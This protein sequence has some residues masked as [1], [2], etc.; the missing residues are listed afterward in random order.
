MLELK[1]NLF[2]IWIGSLLLLLPFD[3]F[4]QRS[5]K[6]QKAKKKEAAAP[7]KAP[8]QVVPLTAPGSARDSIPA[9]DSLVLPK[10]SAKVDTV[11]GDLSTT[12]VYTAEDS[13][14]MEAQ[15]KEVHLYGNASVTYGEINLKADYIRLNWVLNE[16]YAIGREDT[17]TKKMVGEPI[18]Q[19]GQSTYNTK[20]IRYNFKTKKG[21]IKGIITQEGDGNIRGQ[22][23]KKDS[24]N[25]FYLAKAMYTTCNMEHPHYYINAPKIKL[26][27]KKQ[28]ISGLFNLV[29][30][31]VPLPLGLPFGFFPLPKNK[32]SGTSGILFPTYGED[33]MR[34]FYLRDGGYYFAINEY[35]NAA[36][37]G[38]FYTSGSWGV[39]LESSYMSRYK[40]SGNV[41]LRFNR[42]RS[43]DEVNKILKND[44]RNDF[45]LSWSHTPKPRGSST[46]SANVNIGSD[47]YNSLNA[48]DIN[49]YISNTASSS[50]QYNKTFGSF[51]RAG[52]SL[53]V[54]QNFGSIDAQT[55]I[56]KNG[57]TNVSSD[58][59]FGINQFSPFTIGGQARGRW[60]E[61]FRLGMDFSG[62]YGVTNTLAAID[63]SYAT[64]R[65][66][67][68]NPIDT[69]RLKQK[70]L[71]I[72]GPN[73]PTIFD[74]G[75]FQGRYSI[76]ISLP[77]MKL[78]K[79]I[80]VTPSVSFQGELFNRAY[81]YTYQGNNRI[82]ID[83][84]EAIYT[85][86]AY[87]FG[88]GMN[89]RFYGLFQVRKGRLETIR[90][91]VIPN[92]S[93][94]YTPDFSRNRNFYQEVQINDKGEKRTFSKYKNLATGGNGRASGMVNFGLGNQLEMK[95]RSKNDTAEN[96]FE[97][98]SLL[99][100]LS[101]NG[102]YNL[103]ADSLN[104][105]N[106]S[107]SA[108]TRLGK[109]LNMNFN[110]NFDPYIYEAYPGSTSGVRV[111]KFAITHGQGLA[112]L[113][114]MNFSLNTSFNPAARK[115]NTE[116]NKQKTGASEEQLEFI[117][118]NPDLYVDFNIPWNVNVSYNFGWNR[119]GLAPSNTVQALNF[120]GDLSLTPKWKI[121]VS[122]G[123]DFAAL[124]PTITQVT[125]YRDLHC[126]EMSLSWTPYAGSSVRASNYNF[127]LKVKSS[128]LQDLKLTRRRSFYD[129]GGMY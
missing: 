111:N 1:K 38:Q 22:R 116:Q 57:T 87:N 61:S 33:A 3:T 27:E 30:S 47:S 43:G 102:N 98:V 127:T 39:G 104:L 15:K 31:D 42:N 8:A 6:S 44:I 72:N 45:K 77:N 19:E 79:H 62:N 34:G 10:D 121:T 24:L 64:L 70:V 9:G 40:Y 18:F 60:Y 52:A 67:I 114:N 2:I 106:I 55:Q 88:A 58:F 128:I 118:Q 125:I 110:M 120:N 36:I 4:S 84:T 92:V 74:N 49:T 76:P 51:A 78:L 124:S 54:N 12:V 119:T 17:A 86:Y 103:L 82:R 53:R 112:R 20:E 63:T 126:W 66:I 48:A 21:I 91:T 113:Q 28:V 83:T 50:V 97:K 13:T 105:S 65:F 16:V 35:V 41:M 26:V 7:V 100:N 59:N 129:S 14:I 117:D 73:L 108:N 101:I 94:S 68:D 85:Q 123:F 122:S 46:F 71:A 11:V 99:D 89:T 90:H 29:I 32:E 107:L 23:V 95:L 96:Q 81:N 93:F 25:N 37:L 69:S 115:V 56:R 5:T 80:N 109:N 75:T